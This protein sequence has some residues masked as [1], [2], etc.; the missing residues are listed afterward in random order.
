[1]SLSNS[2]LF[3]YRS[4]LKTT[5]PQPSPDFG[6]KKQLD[7]SDVNEPQHATSLGGGGGGGRRLRP[8]RLKLARHKWLFP[9]MNPPVG[10][11]LP[12]SEVHGRRLG[13]LVGN[14]LLEVL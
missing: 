2:L 6:G 5:R 14:G 12:L 11:D 1:M 4:R 10:E 9:Q 7:H 3:M 13:G 8:A